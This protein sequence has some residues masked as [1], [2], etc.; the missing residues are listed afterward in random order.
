MIITDVILTLGTYKTK[1]DLQGGSNYVYI[2]IAQRSAKTSEAAWLIR[3]L[4]YD[5][6]GNVTDSLISKPGQVWDNRTG[7]DYAPS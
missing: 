7:L 4:L 2:G 5:G 3:K 1:Y 6:N